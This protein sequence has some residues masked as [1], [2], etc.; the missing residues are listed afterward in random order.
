MAHGW[1][2]PQ[3]GPRGTGGP[4]D[5]TPRAR[6]MGPVG[7]EGLRLI[8]VFWGGQWGAAH[9]RKTCMGWVGGADP[10]LYLLVPAPD[11]DPPGEAAGRTPSDSRDGRKP[12]VWE[13]MR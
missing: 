9:L 10:R 2:C 4:R 8:Y 6:G 11:V 5:T 7:G 13:Q 3:A 1:L 12:S